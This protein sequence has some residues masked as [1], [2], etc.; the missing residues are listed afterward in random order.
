[1]KKLLNILL[2]LLTMIYSIWYS[3]LGGFR[4]N[5]GALST[6]GL[7]HR[8]LFAIWGVMTYITLTVNIIIGFKKT[9]FRFYIPLLVLSAMG[10]IL[11]LTCRF[12]YKYYYEY[13]LHC[14]GSMS[15]S[16]ITGITVLSLFIS[17]KRIGL[18]IICTVILLTDL[19][20]LLIFK[21]TAIIELFP[22]FSGYIM[23]GILN[24]KKEKAL[25]EAKR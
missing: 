24:F 25:I 12:E 2:I 7:E 3:S 15:F 22:I 6:I 5:A 1:M 9:K 13:L 21:E 10:M 11:T 17:R 4:G 14:I 8:V 20:L 19:V 18:S 23:L 16:I